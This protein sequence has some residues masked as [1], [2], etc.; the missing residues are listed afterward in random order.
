MA[1]HARPVA[2]L[3]YLSL[4][5]N[6][7]TWDVVLIASEEEQGL[8]VLCV[9][10]SLP[11]W[12]TPLQELLY[13]SRWRFCASPKLPMSWWLISAHLSMCRVSA[14]LLD[15]DKLSLASRGIVITHMCLGVFF[16]TPAW[17]CT[18]F[19]MYGK[20]T[21]MHKSQKWRRTYMG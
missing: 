9:K 8:Y 3:T 11:R 14:K 16:R 19:F 10:I 17:L 2:K 12:Y 15:C 5:V 1:Q 7:G 20:P 18:Y 21:A 13:W 4:G 6:T